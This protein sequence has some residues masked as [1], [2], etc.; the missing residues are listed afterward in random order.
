MTPLRIGIV[1][2]GF[3]G[4]LLAIQLIEQACSP[5][6]LYWIDRPEAFG[7]GLAYS[8]YSEALLLN[9]MA[10]KMSAFP[11]QPHH[12]LDW[13][14]DQGVY[15]AAERDWLAQAFVPRAWYGRY[16][17][18]LWP[19]A[20]AQAERKGIRVHR[21]E[22][23]LSDLQLGQ[24]QQWRLDN[25]LEL[26][27]D[28]TI[29]ATGNALP[30]HPNLAD[31]A[32][33]HHPRYHQN[34]WAAAAVSPPYT[35][36]PIFILGN[37]LTMVDTVLGLLERGCT[38]P[39]YA[40]SPNG[41]NMLP[42]R[43]NGL[44]YTA[45]QADLENQTDLLS[46][47]R[48]VHRHVKKVR[49]LGL[50]AEPVVDALRPHTQRLWQGLS[51][52]DKR[53]F[54]RRLRHLWGVARHRIPLHIHDRIQQL[55]LQGQLNVFAG[56]I[57][58]IE[59]QGQGLLVSFRQRGKEEIQSLFVDRLI[60]CTGPETKLAALQGHFL[61]KM[62]ARGDIQQDPL[63]LGLAVRVVDFSVEGSQTEQ[64][65]HLYAIGPLL[66]GML[67]ESTAVNE[68]RQ[69]AKDLAAVICRDWLKG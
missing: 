16:L 61:Q 33:Q 64:R 9:V 36:L 25:G 54:M 22:A 15:P 5:F 32:Y 58:S 55:R 8:P 51:L 45:L 2:A 42:H 39:I 4:T 41:Y 67:W 46:L 24:P 13:L 23:W 50:S 19:V 62:A 18:S 11:D 12:F 57:L 7:R 30:G 65:P 26:P 63:E 6:E 56:K 29:L 37:G 10:G 53:L 66:K 17:L 35:E 28:L 40:L 21:L 1:G 52:A 44:T 43:P 34:P 3:S 14:L 69:Q 48:V 27:M 49:R 47:F 31:Q 20:Q 38:Q 68:L 59:A 60:N